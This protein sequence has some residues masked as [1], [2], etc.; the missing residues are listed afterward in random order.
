MRRFLF[1]IFILSFISCVQ[2]QQVIDKVIAVVGKYPVL[3]SDL[4]S[5]I[6]DKKKEE[7]KVDRCRSLE[8]VVYQKMLL[9]Q[10]DRDSVTVSDNEVEGELTRRMAYYI[11][12]I[13]GEDK[14]ENFYGMRTNV[15]KDQMRDDVHSQLLAQKMQGK[16]TGDIKLTPSEVRQFLSTIPEDSLPIINSE[17]EIGQIIR[18]PPI[19][20]QAKK[21]AREIIESY[22]QRVISGEG[23]H[24]LAALY[25]EDPGSA[26][27]GGVYEFGR[28]MMTPEFEAVAF[29][30]KPGEISEV[31]ETPFGY[32]FIQLIARKGETVE[33]R[34]ILIAPKITTEDIFREKL[35]LDSLQKEIIEK[36]ISFEDAAKR[37]S[38]DNETKQNGGLMINQS[39]GTT[40]WDDEDLA[41][42][43]P[44]LVK[45]FDDMNIGDVTA[46]M[47]FNDVD[48]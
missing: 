34:H 18:K 40:K 7:G 4:E 36:K 2:A 42:M 46:P 15:F 48:S 31:F 28:G 19:S 6:L 43:D 13:G 29:R 12:M 30:L 3:L 35:F 5:S 47:Q 27:K 44:T 8:D 25:S 21:D 45:V 17:V 32:H 1:I 23:M 37:Y 10:A 38:T 26:K 16:I 24:M 39:N 41:K 14:F 11:Q 9:A 20:E 33:A 22:R